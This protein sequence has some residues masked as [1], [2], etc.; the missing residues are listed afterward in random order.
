M[1]GGGKASIMHNTETCSMFQFA[2]RCSISSVIF[3]Y[4]CN[5]SLFF[6]WQ[7]PT[8]S[9]S[10]RSSPLLWERRR[11]DSWVQRNV[12][13]CFLLPTSWRQNMWD[14]V[15][16]SSKMFDYTDTDLQYVPRHNAVYSSQ[17]T[18]ISKSERKEKCR[19]RI[20]IVSY[21]SPFIFIK[22]SFW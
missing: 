9:D 7:L 13:K 17:I 16:S 14:L 18:I 21:R 10:P 3:L 20:I 12:M 1:L 6:C 4:F 8:S 22:P 5:T 11:G 2:L 19:K 15:Q